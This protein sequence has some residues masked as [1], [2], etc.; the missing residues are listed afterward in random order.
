MDIQKSLGQ[1]LSSET[2]ACGGLVRAPEKTHQV[3]ERKIIP[4]QRCQDRAAREQQLRIMDRERLSTIIKLFTGHGRFKA[5]WKTMSLIDEDLRRY[6]DEATEDIIHI[7]C[8]SSSPGVSEVTVLGCGRHSS[9]PIN[10]EK[11]KPQKSQG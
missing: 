6:Y 5:H 10:S 9:T 4:G 2:F 1:K 3:R 8:I 11:Q 7:L